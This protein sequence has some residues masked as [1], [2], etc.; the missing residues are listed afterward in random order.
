MQGHEL[1]NLTKRNQQ[2]YD[3]YTRIDIECNRI[4][5]ELMTANG[6]VEQLR[7]E[8]ANLRAEKRIWE[9]CFFKYYSS[10]LV[11]KSH[12]DDT[13]CSKPPTRREQSSFYGTFSLVQLDVQC[14]EDA[15][16]PGTLW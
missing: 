14:A 7:N 8:C 11:G 1:D 15:Q 3:Q 16:R 4:T 6:L 13:E 9:V 12:D 10:E 5:E 2:L